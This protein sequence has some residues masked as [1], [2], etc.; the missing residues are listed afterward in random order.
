MSF[1]QFQRMRTSLTAR[2][3]K[4][5]RKHLSSRRPRSEALLRIQEEAWEMSQS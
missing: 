1:P 4:Q 3:G 2:S 5:I